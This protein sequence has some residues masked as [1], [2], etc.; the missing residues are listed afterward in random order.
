MISTD[1][2]CMSC[3]K[4]IGNEKKCPHCGYYVDSAQIQPYL[5]VRTVIGN[6]YLV[7]KMLDYNGEGATY[8]GWDMTERKA[9]N[10]REF[11]PDAFTTRNNS[12]LNLQVSLGSEAT[13]AELRRSF[14]ELW[15]KLAKLNG[16][17]ALIHVTAVLEDYGTS[18]AVYDYFDGISLRDFLLRTKTGYV[19]WE[20]ARQLLMPTLSTLATL[21]SNG[22]IHRGIS[23]TTLI[24]AE[25]GKI[26]ITGFSI[27][28]V[29]TTGSQLT[30]QIYNNFAAVEQYGL[31]ARQGAWTDIYA[32]GAV[33]YRTLIGS[34]PI[35]AKERM[36]N[37][38]LMVPGKFAEAIPAYV[39][40]GLVNALQILPQDRTKTVEQLRADLSASPAASA[41][42]AQRAYEQSKQA[43]RQREAQNAAEIRKEPKG[44]ASTII[45]TALIFA[46]VGLIAFGILSLTVFRDKFNF[47]ASSSGG[48]KV[49]A[50]NEPTVVPNFVDRSF[51]D[52]ESN[53]VF[54]S[55]FEIEKEEIFSET[56]PK[57]YIVSQ[58]IEPDKMVDSGTKIILY[59]SKGKE[60]VV[61][62]NVENTDYDEAEARLSELGFVVQRSETSEGS[63]RENYVISMAPI[64]EKSYEKGTKVI[65]KV[66]VPEVQPEITTKPYT[67]VTKA[68]TT[69]SDENTTSGESDTGITINDDLGD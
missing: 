54:N 26:K 14:E 20:K 3:M 51:L 39:I 41:A 61:L 58:S 55:S 66:Y 69:E 57:G 68:D 8:I 17:S 32:F 64:A 10:I 34:D 28:E 23:P 48:E 67:I 42:G 46:L 2:L 18:Y 15:S 45:I 13:F 53:P 49:S 12:S 60:V 21:H 40:N 22:I 38:K 25:D 9:V 30:P 44:G 7:G 31:D 29:R 1:N 47:S 6:R 36:S 27:G 63:Y 37:D 62:P 43:N 24:I 5:P 4:E 33:L 19:S 35:P 59:V 52:V 16:L 56:V 65:L 11:I 50:E